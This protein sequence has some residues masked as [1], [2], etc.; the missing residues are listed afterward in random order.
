MSSNY[1]P[2][3]DQKFPDSHAAHLRTQMDAIALLY[4]IV[5]CNGNADKAA[6][7]LRKQQQE[8]VSFERN[9]IWKDM[10]GQERRAATLH[11]QVSC[12]Q[13]LLCCSIVLQQS[14]QI[15]I[16]LGL[17]DALLSGFACV[18]LNSPTVHHSRI[19]R[20]HKHPAC[21]SYLTPTSCFLVAPLHSAVLSTCAYKHLQDGKEAVQESCFSMHR[22][23]LL[24][25]FALAV[26]VFLLS[27]PIF[28]VR[29][30]LVLLASSCNGVP[31]LL[32]QRWLG[33]T[34]AAS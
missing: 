15:P 14:A 4:S 25:A 16:Q 5:C 24:V 17:A 1:L 31:E 6:A 13:A 2:I 7:I 32:I 22:Q 29:C 26:F 33:I 30:V 34:K 3:V 12:W 18:P 19:A 11:V 10:V 21:K 27:Y 23:A 8:Q 20:T 9:S 28:K